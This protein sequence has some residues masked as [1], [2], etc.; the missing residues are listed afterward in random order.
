MA[1]PDIS[2][3]IAVRNG[4]PWIADQLDA[5]CRQDFGGSWELLVSDNGSSDGTQARV[6]SYI[7]KLP[8]RLVDSGHQPGTGPARN[9]GARATTGA[10]LAFCDADDVVAP[11]WLSA[12]ARGLQDA[13]AVGGHV[14][15]DLLNDPQV[16]AW[17]PAATPGA[18]PVPFGF[19]PAPFG[20]NCGIRSDVFRSLGGFDEAW[21]AVA[22]EDTDL[23]WRAQ[24]AGHTLAYAPKAIVHY[25]HRRGLP[26][27]MR[28]Y[29][30]YGVSSAR[31]VQRYAA[32]L[33]RESSRDEAKTVAW[34][35]VHAADLLRGAA[36][37]NRYLRTVAHLGGQWRGSRRFAT[38]HYA[39][40]RTTPAAPT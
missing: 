24:I 35:V 23:F 9:A 38:R 36:R 30:S 21:G 39:M 5:L 26:A 34:L 27:L 4:L 17:R 15:E 2:V 29:R 14:E 25:R 1:G 22:A 19:L 8:L 33:P 11:G 20:C 32:Q 28:Q 40:N 3:V 10:L 16:V 37:R 31:L 7:G 6:A 13:D 18:L 12:I